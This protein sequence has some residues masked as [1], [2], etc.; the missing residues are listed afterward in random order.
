[1]F[2]FLKKNYK[3]LVLL[4]IIVIFFSFSFTITWDSSHYMSYVRIL[5]GKLPISTWDIV[6][7]PI[8]PIIIY[9][10]LLFFGETIQGLLILSFMFF[11]VYGFFI[12]KILNTFIKNKYLKL[13]LLIFCLFNPIIFG[14]FHTL[15]TEFVAITLSVISCYMSYLWCTTKDKKKLNCISIFYIFA[16][17]FSWHLKQPYICC[18]L[19]PMIISIIIA[20]FNNH[21]IK[22]ICYYFK[23][24]SFSIALLVL[25]IFFWNKF[26]IINNVNMSTGR[27]SSSMLANQLMLG[28]QYFMYDDNFDFENYD[29]NIYLSDSEKEYIKKNLNNES[30]NLKAIFIYNNN[31]IVDIDIIK[32]DLNGNPST[33]DVVLQIIK[34]FIKHPSIIL[35]NYIKNYCAL[36]SICKINSLDSVVYHVTN[37][38]DFLN[39]FEHNSIAYRI[40][41]QGYEN[42]FYLSEEGA[43]LTNNFIQEN[44][45]GIFNNFFV[46]MKIPTNILYKIT[47][48]VQPII[49]FILM[50][51]FI[52]SIIKYKII[53][54]N[55][56]FLITFI[57]TA[58][59]FFT[60]L[61]NALS[62]A[63]IDRYAV[64]CFIPGIIG[65]C[66]FITLI[67]KAAKK[68]MHK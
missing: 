50:V 25:S 22:N 4:L 55:N 13:I 31:E 18:I 11:I 63:I 46:I 40:F 48:I 24:L 61:A 44:R 10:G 35:K 34:T 36:S 33:K 54:V 42:R 47:I 5:Q 12:F 41:N 1:M 43:A 56:L 28:V 57:F 26:L 39:T 20:I 53:K 32:V 65:I 59:T 19:F 38:F 29:N 2:E 37:E 8:F 67:I 3:I 14:Y 68:N 64:C 23:T 52:T 21:S 15:L 17:A 27:D 51:M 16:L 60:V 30:N 7:G 66:S 49:L 6:R 9:L 58:Y 45:L 62:G